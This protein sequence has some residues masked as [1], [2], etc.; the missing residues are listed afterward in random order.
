[1]SDLVIFPGRFLNHIKGNNNFFIIRMT[2]HTSHMYIHYMY[3][4]RRL[5]CNR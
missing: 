4:M 2:H 1:V 3:Y 5:Y